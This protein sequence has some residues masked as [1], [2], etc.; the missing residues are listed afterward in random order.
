MPGHGLGRRPEGGGRRGGGGGLAEVGGAGAGALAPEGGAVEGDEGGQGEEDHERARGQG[1]GGA[2][3]RQ[4]GAQVGARG[5]ETDAVGE[6][7]HEPV[8]SYPNR[9]AAKQLPRAPTDER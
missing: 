9:S 2:D 4:V 1:A 3:P 7:G 6:T 5:A 8:R